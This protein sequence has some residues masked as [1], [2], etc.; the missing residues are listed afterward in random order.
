MAVNEPWRLYVAASTDVIPAGLAM[1]DHPRDHAVVL[2]GSI[3]GLLAARVLTEHYDHVTVIERDLLPARP[4]H[5]QG[6]PHDRHFHGLL[7][8]GVQVIERLLPGITAALTAAGGLAGDVLGH[9][10]WYLRG[11]MLQ[12]ADS[13]LTML[14]ASRPLIEAALRDRVRALPNIRM[15]DG[16]QATGLCTSADR[17]QITG[18]LVTP[19]AGGADLQFPADLVVDATGRRTRA[20]LW[21]EELGYPPPPADQVR[22]WLRYVT[23]VFAAPPAI[24]GTD[25]MVAIAPQPRQKRSGVMQRIEG[26]R[27]LV[28]LA[29][30]YGDRPPLNPDGFADYAATLAAPDI[31][32]LIRASK[33]LTAP[34]QFHCPTYERHHYEQLTTFPAGLLA[35]GDAICSFNPVYSEGICAAARTAMALQEQLSHSHEPTAAGFFRSAST[36]LDTP[37]GL[38]AS[39]DLTAAGGAAPPLPTWPLTANYRACLEAAAPDDAIL[40]AAYVRVAAL[41]DPPAALLSP[42]IQRRVTAAGHGK[43][44]GSLDARPSVQPD[45]ESAVD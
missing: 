37:W 31:H 10:R 28:T 33:P 16:H 39:S 23:R 40:S 24:L 25:I 41:I 38:T 22:I 43:Q 35:I 9:I 29:G 32:Q 45:Q 1:A 20:R 17:R 7:P 30:V 19:R 6:T 3:A 13:G 11:R 15:L 8:H 26:N 5:R 14:S 21:L 12:Q 27:V 42:A 34:A 44:P 18:A 4:Q 2:G 36:V